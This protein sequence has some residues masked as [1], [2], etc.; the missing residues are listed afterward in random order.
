[1]YRNTT[2]AKT[3]NCITDIKLIMD[4][5]RIVLL[6]DDDEDD[7]F[8]FQEALAD[9]DPSVVFFSSNN[10]CEALERLGTRGFSPDIIFMDI[11]MPVMNGIECLKKIK[12]SKNYNKIPVIMYSTSGNDD[13]RQECINLGANGFIQKPF[14]MMKMR[15]EIK[16][17]MDSL[18][19]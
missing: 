1:M 11:N 5:N 13:A 18:S 9:V 2:A 19:E 8:I 12:E 10:G 3:L 4:K 15:D 17:A 7:R 6:A 16:N 14:S